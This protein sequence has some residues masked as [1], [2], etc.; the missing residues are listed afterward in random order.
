[1]EIWTGQER[2]G[3]QINHCGSDK[4]IAVVGVRGKGVEEGRAQ[5][6]CP[7]YFC[8]VKNLEPDILPPNS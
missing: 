5:E 2:S 8:L 3:I 7:K 6:A 1:M 4:F